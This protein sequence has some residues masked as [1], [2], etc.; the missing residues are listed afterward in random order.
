MCCAL[1]VMKEP[2]L[3]GDNNPIFVRNI[4]VIGIKT[5][6]KV[7]ILDL[8]N[9]LDQKDNLNRLKDKNITIEKISALHD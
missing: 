7:M 5:K 9:I 2:I 3:F 8:A 6:E 1:L 4:V